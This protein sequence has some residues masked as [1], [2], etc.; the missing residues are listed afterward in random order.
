VSRADAFRRGLLDA[1]QPAPAG[2]GDGRGASTGKRYDVYRNNVT[3][4]LVQ[5]MGQAFPLVRRLLGAAR[6]DALARDF[7]RAHPPASPILMHYGRDF[8]AF[9]EN[10]ESLRRLGYLPDAAR[11]DLALRSSYH[12]ADAAPLD[13]TPLRS[14]PQNAVLRLAP[15]TRVLRSRWPLFAIWRY[16]NEDDAPKPRAEAQ[17]VLI[18]R[19]DY[20]PRPT[21]L[22][23]GGA[24]WLAALEAG[25][26][27][28][29]A[30]R[31]ATVAC[32]AFDLGSTLSTCLAAQAFAGKPAP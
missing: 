22:P 23:P 26:T 12:A 29:E 8:P 21:L 25:Q 15:S 16:N 11:L 24:D 20:D 6:F 14:D 28:G 27:L 30:S 18:T 13:T 2:I 1:D 19:I 9:V 10:V 4:S 7:V 3:H 31:S 17:D 32:P 5:A